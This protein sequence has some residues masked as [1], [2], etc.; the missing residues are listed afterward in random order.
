MP[1]ARLKQL[2]A[3]ADCFDGP[4]RFISHACRILRGFQVLAGAKQRL[5]AVGSDCLDAEAHLARP[6]VRWLPVLDAEPLRRWKWN[7]LSSERAEART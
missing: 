2:D 4:G 5:G 1:V 6:G 7:W 3:V